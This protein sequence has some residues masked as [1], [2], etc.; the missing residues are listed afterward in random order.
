MRKKNLK[1]FFTRM[2]LKNSNLFFFPDFIIIP[3][4]LSARFLSS[5]AVPVSKNDFYEGM[6]SRLKIYFIEGTTKIVL[7]LPPGYKQEVQI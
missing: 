6:F 5:P 1:H 2:K 3:R 4:I 7:K